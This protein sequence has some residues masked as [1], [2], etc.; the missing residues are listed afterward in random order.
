MMSAYDEFFVQDE[1]GRGPKISRDLVAQAELSLGV[2]LPREYLFLLEVRNGG[3]P[4]RRCFRTSR[5]TS[6]ARS[7][8]EVQTLRGIGYDLGIDGEFGSAYMIQEWGYPSLGVVLFDTPAAGPDTV[9]LDYSGCGPRGDPSVVY[10]DEGGTVL[11]VAGNFSEFIAGLVDR[12][13]VDQC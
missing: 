2:R 1:L 7:H 5:P 10:V 8:F 11:K 6:W 9:M 13:S 3:K 4:R 12:S